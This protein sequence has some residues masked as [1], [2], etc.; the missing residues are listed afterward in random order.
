MGDASPSRMGCPI[1]RVLPANSTLLLVPVE[2]NAPLSSN[3]GRGWLFALSLCLLDELV[4]FLDFEQGILA[5]LLPSCCALNQD[6]H[7]QLASPA[8]SL[9]AH[10]T[11]T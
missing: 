9:E 4:E 1:L 2:R 8:S 6:A 10:I 11:Q 3:Q 7:W 5:Q